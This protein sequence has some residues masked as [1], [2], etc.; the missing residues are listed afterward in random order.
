MRK[1][2]SFFRKEHRTFLIISSLHTKTTY[3]IE[4]ICTNRMT[5]FSTQRADRNLS[6]K[7]TQRT[8]WLPS[9]NALPTSSWKLFEH[10]TASMYTSL[11]SARLK[12]K[13]G[14]FFSQYS[15]SES[16]VNMVFLTISFCCT[17]VHSLVYTSY[18]RSTCMRFLVKNNIS[19]VPVNILG[20]Q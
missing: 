4:L 5:K 12:V 9:S 2:I 13:D 1:Q 11:F 19:R 6:F 15:I 8:S 18:T 3:F 16:S 14:S 10:S 20:A 17:E 7:I